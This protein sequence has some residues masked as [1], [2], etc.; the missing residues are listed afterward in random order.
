MRRNWLRAAAEPRPRQ[1]ATAGS[2][3]EPFRLDAPRTMTSQNPIL[4]G[5]AAAS[6]ISRLL[7]NCDRQIVH[8]SVRMLDHTIGVTGRKRVLVEDA[9]SGAWMAAIPYADLYR[10]GRMKRH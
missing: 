6:M 3:I 1:S 5:N 8:R 4:V 10:H 9:G 7:L 2:T